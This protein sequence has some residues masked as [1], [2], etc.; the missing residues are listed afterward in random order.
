MRRHGMILFL[1]ALLILP[2]MAITFTSCGG[3]TGTTGTST[4][5]TDEEKALAKAK[6]DREA[7]EEAARKKQEALDAK[8]DREKREAMERS[9]IARAQVERSVKMAKTSFL[10]DHAQFDFDKYNIRPDAA[11]ILRAKAIFMSQNPNMVV[12]IQGHCD[13]RGTNDYNLALG[14]RRAHAAAK[15]MESLGISRD[16][17]STISYGEEQPLDAGHYEDAWAKNRRAQFQIVTE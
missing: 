7:R 2:V 9:S 12:E 5:M 1:V 13:E 16:R 14:D 17:M 15:F 4:E 3:T 10:N 11:D 6:A 8:K